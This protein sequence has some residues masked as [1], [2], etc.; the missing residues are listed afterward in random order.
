MQQVSAARRKSIIENVQ[1]FLGALVVAVI[2]W[3]LAVTT[4]N[5]VVQWRLPQSVPIRLSPDTGMIIVNEE[6]LSRNATVTL[7]GPS[8]VQELMTPDDVIVYGDLNGL[9]AGT[10][11]VPLQAEVALNAVVEAISPSQLTVILELQAAQFVPVREEIVQPPPADVQIGNIAFDVLQAE[12][13]GPQSRVQQVVAAVAPLDLSNQRASFETDVRLIPVNVDGEEVPDVVVTPPSAHATITISQRDNVRE[14]SVQP[15]LEG[16][17]PAGYFLSTLTYTPQTVYLSGP[18][19]VLQ[20]LPSTV[21]TAAIDLSSAREDFQVVVPIEP[22]SD[23]VVPVSLSNITVTIGVDAQTGSEQLDGVPVELVGRREGFL[24]T[25]DPERVSL[26][27]TGP[28]HVL[29]ALTAADVQVSADVSAY[30]TPGSYRTAVS[31]ILPADI[32]G[33]TVT[34]L[35]AD[36]TVVVATVPPRAASP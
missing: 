9:P 19:D 17:L 3:L 35:P 16:S 34:A 6:V 12:I 14:F 31:V 20:N 26:V 22:D 32:S 27:I 7:R 36:V 29:D 28:Q 13:S 10:H 5:P 15:R 4:Q 30:T 18:S 2:I 23:E 1:W 8:S 21:F 24:Y 33:A 11:T 25:V